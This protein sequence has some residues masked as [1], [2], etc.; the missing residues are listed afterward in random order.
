VNKLRP[1]L[2]LKLSARWHR[3]WRNAQWKASILSA[4]PAGCSIRATRFTAVANGT[5]SI[6]TS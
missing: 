1:N 5:S 6:K 4:A 2:R 3:F